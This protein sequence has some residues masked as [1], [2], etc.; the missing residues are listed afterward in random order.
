MWK[1]SAV[2]A[3]TLTVALMMGLSTM[4]RTANADEGDRCGGN[5]SPV[6]RKIEVCVQAPGTDNKVCTKDFYYFPADE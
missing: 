3:I 1:R 4:P 2:A 5:V 6:C